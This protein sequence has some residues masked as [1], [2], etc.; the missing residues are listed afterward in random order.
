MGNGI[1]GFKNCNPFCC[2]N[3]HYEINN[4]VYENYEE[5]NLDKHKKII[6]NIFIPNC[7]VKI[8]PQGTIDKDN[9]QNYESPI[10]LE[11][12]KKKFKTEKTFDKKESCELKNQL[13]K[14]FNQAIKKTTNKGIDLISPEQSDS[15]NFSQIKKKFAFNNY[16][17]DFFEYL[18]KLRTNP[19]SIIEDIDYIW[20]NNMKIMDERDYLVSDMTNEI[21]KLKDNFISFENI[22][23]FLENEQ[24]VNALNLNNNLK[25]TSN[26]D[27]IELTDNKINEIV[28]EKKREIIYQFPNCFF[29]P[30]FIKDIKLNIIILLSN[31]ILREKIF[32]DEFTEFYL[33]TFNIKNNRFFSILCFA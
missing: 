18:N 23:Y 22:K 1:F 10:P 6:T 21:I 2:G 16:T 31:S 30:I 29:Y 26:D 13:N 4:N 12:N 9:T 7:Q 15:T 27:I 28:L 14:Y 32:F 33:T 5:M 19:N 8:S 11:K 25:F 20:K 3:S 17:N 24:P